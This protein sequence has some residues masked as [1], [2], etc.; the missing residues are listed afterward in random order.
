[1]KLIITPHNLGLWAAGY[2]VSRVHTAAKDPF[3][4][5]L[6][7]GSTVEEMYAALCS[8]AKH[9]KIDFAHIHTFNMDEYV[10][11][12]PS[13]P[14][15]YAYYMHQ[16]LFDHVDMPPQNIHLLDGLTTDIPKTCQQYE[17]AIKQLGGIDLFLGGVG[18][19]GHLAF[20]E[21]GSTLDSPTRVIELTESTRQANARFFHNDPTQV[22]VQALTVGIGTILEA[23]ELLFLA[24]GAAK[25]AP[26]ARLA[27]GDI[28]PAWPITALHAHTRATLLIDPAA[29]GAL[30]HA[31][32]D[33]WQQHHRAHPEQDFCIEL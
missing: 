16:H 30:P 33:A 15:S 26:V 1:M 22:P 6:P 17:T 13:H 29:A 19:N 31:W 32:Q 21:P 8:L 27:Q 4:L 5:G 25:A 7:T 3:V 24:S 9:Q 10:G 28:T 12:P 14:Q 11:L 18:R 23:K 2:I 20:N